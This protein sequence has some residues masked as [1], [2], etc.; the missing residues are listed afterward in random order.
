MQ[1]IAT[2]I[3]KDFRGGSSLPVLVRGSDHQF[4]VVKWQ[5]TG[6]GVIASI[7]DLI[8]MNLAHL[9]GITVPLA[10][11][12]TIPAALCRG[13]MDAELKDLIMRS[14]GT[15]LALEYLP[16]AMGYKETDLPGIDRNL[17]DKIF[18]FDLLMLNI[19]RVDVN[20]NML[21][22]NGTLFCIDFSTSMAIRE[23]LVPRNI[24]VPALL[25]LI[26]RHPFYSETAAP[27]T[28]AFTIADNAVKQII[29]TIPTEWLD[30]IDDNTA[31]L[32]CQLLE[33]ITRLIDNRT[34]I[35]EQRLPELRQVHFQ[36]IEERRKASRKNLTDFFSRLAR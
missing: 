33:G 11:L 3:L 4:Y 15:N 28:V 17:A 27:M 8:T 30:E 26:R 5:G 6:E 35:L 13:S 20:P 2:E 25:A 32:R 18:L 12:I 10:G 9:A 1:V 31:G 21:L 7:T 23:L 29:E 16:E 14:L 24:A 19:D 36:S 34:A 22:M